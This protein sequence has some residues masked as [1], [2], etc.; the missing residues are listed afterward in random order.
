VWGSILFW[1]DSQPEVL[2]FGC[3]AGML[4]TGWGHSQPKKRTMWQRRWMCCRTRAKQEGAV[5]DGNAV[6]GRVRCAF[7]D[8]S[9]G[10]DVKRGGDKNGGAREGKLAD[11]KR[12]CRK[13]QHVSRWRVE[14][15]RRCYKIQHN[16]QLART[17]RGGQGWM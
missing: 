14:R 3:R 4:P 7:E 5:A 12:R 2:T 16:N 15:R 17:K 8:T 6:A 13:R 1:H 11:V 9:D 10:H